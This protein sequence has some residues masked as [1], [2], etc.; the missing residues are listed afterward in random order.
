MLLV[1]AP[2]ATADP[3][4]VEEY[5]LSLPGVEQSN[6]QPPTALE[7]SAEAI[8]RVGV[9]G[10]QNDNFTRIGALSAAAASPGGALALVFLAGGIVLALLRRRE[11]D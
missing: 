5:V 8:G 9:V 10:E 3:A 11:R 6:V 1:T 4:A 2:A 7:E